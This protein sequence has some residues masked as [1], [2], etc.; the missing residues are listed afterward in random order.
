MKDTA[1][2][3]F[4]AP[5]AATATPAQRHELAPCRAAACLLPLLLLLHANQQQPSSPCACD[6]RI[7]ITGAQ[8]HCLTRLRGIILRLCLCLLLAAL[9]TMGAAG[10]GAAVAPLTFAAASAEDPLR[11]AV[12]GSADTSSAASAAMA[13][14]AAASASNGPASSNTVMGGCG[15]RSSADASIVAA[16]TAK[17]VSS[18]AAAAG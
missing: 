14:M 12:S 8:Q 16:C 15:W 4:D 9:L 3:T 10:A 17:G 2:C 11:A 13:A 18:S 5:P 6:A 7:H 1:A